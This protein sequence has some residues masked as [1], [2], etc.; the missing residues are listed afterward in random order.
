[1]THAVPP[2]VVQ[3]VQ[4]EHPAACARLHIAGQLNDSDKLVILI[5]VG[6]GQDELGQGKQQLAPPLD[7]GKLGH[8]YGLGRSDG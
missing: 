6:V 8:A 3:T 1:M 2:V 7:R 4:V 5:D